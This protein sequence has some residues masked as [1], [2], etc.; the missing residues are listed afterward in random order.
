MPCRLK[1]KVTAGSQQLNTNG[2]ISL[3]RRSSTRSTMICAFKMGTVS[4]EYCQV[5]MYSLLP[6]MSGQAIMVEES[7]GSLV[8]VGVDVAMALNS[9]DGEGCWEGTIE[10]ASL[11]MEDCDGALEGTI[12]GASLGMA[13][14]DGTLEGVMEGTVLGASE[15]DGAP[16]GIIEE[17]DGAID[18]TIDA[19]G[20]AVGTREG[21]SLSPT[22]CSM[23]VG[24]GLRVGLSVMPAAFF[25][26]MASSKASS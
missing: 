12:E 3:A 6:S 4:T 21:A 13:E 23:V 19:E 24:A 25:F 14:R 7:R 17:S 1:S 9:T 11:G 22:Y 8:V 18:G 16:E 15:Y 2:T 10:G 26:L 5:T 20:A